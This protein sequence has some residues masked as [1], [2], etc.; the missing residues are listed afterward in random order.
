MQSGTKARKLGG[1]REANSAAETVELPTHTDGKVLNC[2]L[3]GHSV[4]T[5]AAVGPSASDFEVQ[6]W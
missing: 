1:R 3:K 5:E 6:R 2:L 4:L